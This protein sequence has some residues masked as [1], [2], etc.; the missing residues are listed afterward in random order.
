MIDSLVFL[1]CGAGILSV[2]VAYALYRKNCAL[3]LKILAA[4]A[5]AAGFFTLWQINSELRTIAG[6]REHGLYDGPMPSFI[7]NPM[8]W[9]L[10]AG[11][12]IHLVVRRRLSGM[13]LLLAIAA[14]PIY[15][16]AIHVPFLLGMLV[17]GTR[18]LK[19]MN[20]IVPALFA[21]VPLPFVLEAGYALAQMD[22]SW[23]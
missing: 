2:P 7:T 21:F 5:L 9:P 18:G 22:D 4:Y 10:I 17:H 8:G 13:I 1:L 19:W 6:Y 3:A 15:S 12:F 14:G 20:E 16:L 11:G 23:I